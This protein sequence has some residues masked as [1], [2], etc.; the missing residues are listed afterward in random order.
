M[1]A[2]RGSTRAATLPSDWQQRRLLVQ[3]RAGGRCQGI[4][5]GQRCTALGTDCDHIDGR[6]NHDIGNLQWLCGP[7]HAAKTKAE[8]A[9]GR[10]AAREAT[11]HE[12]TR[13][14]HPGL[15]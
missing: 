5:D 8:A 9:A 11:R 12:S 7:C 2:W 14:A 13:I 10:T 1:S 15:T 4:K 6:D 3:A